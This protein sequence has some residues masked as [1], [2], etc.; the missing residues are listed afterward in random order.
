M[1]PRGPKLLCL[2]A[3][4][5][6]AVASLVPGCVW[7]PWIP[8][9]RSW[10]PDIVAEPG[11]LSQQ[12]ALNAPYVD[13]L[14]CYSHRCEKRFRLV[15]D[16]P[17]QLVVSA[18]PQF[19]SE[20]AQAWIVLEGITGVLGQ[21]GSGR[22]PHSDV[23]VVAVS[24]AVD[25]GVYFVLIQSVGGPTPYQLTARFTPG[26]GAPAAQPAA[27]A[28]RTPAVPTEGPPPRLVQVSLGG[29]ARANYDPAVSFGALRTFRFPAPAGAGGTGPPGAAME[30]PLDRQIR[31]YLADDLTLKGFRQAS[32][33]ETADLIVGFSR[34]TI[35]RTYSWIP[36][37]Y[38][39]YGL[40]VDPASWGFG[41]QVDPRGTLVVDLVTP[42]NRIAWHAWTTKGLGPGITPGPR[43]DALLRQ[44]VTEVLAGFPPQ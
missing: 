26:A 13:E 12:L 24:R 35:V 18:I 16:R 23:T 42:S 43:T 29:N 9:E 36:A 38:D 2:L 39:R 10:N 31:R 11:D 14:D 22:G 20:D 25:P 3:S 27:S 5:A 21:S 30:Q 19:P 40:G 37:I 4:T 34:G 7:N 8:G 41:G 33:N 15:I 17:G 28:S 32:G 6:I 1:K 44:S